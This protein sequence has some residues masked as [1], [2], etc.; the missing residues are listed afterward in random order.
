MN[1]KLLATVL[2]STMV[3][4][5]MSAYAAVEVPSTEATAAAASSVGVENKITAEGEMV[6]VAINVDIPTKM[7]L[8]LN[9]YNV[10]NVGK[11]LSPVVTITNKGATAVEATLVKFET[12]LT[13]TDTKS[14]ITLATTAILPASVKKEV[15]LY[16][17][18][19]VDATT[20]PV[21]TDFDVKTDAPYVVKATGFVPTKYKPLAKTTGTLK[22]QF[23]GDINSKVIWNDADTIEASPIFTFAPTVIPTT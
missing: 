12:K 22:L 3:L 19:G 14:P 20:D 4:G 23:Q 9:P 11:V 21:T 17:R 16:L 2:A 13:S 10:D 1:K 15:L 18:Q 5:S 6:P 7:P 8:L